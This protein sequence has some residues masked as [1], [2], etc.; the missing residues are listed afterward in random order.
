[1]HLTTDPSA[2]LKAEKAGRDI[3][4]QKAAVAKMINANIMANIILHYKLSNLL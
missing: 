1:M 4:V 3:G 2:V